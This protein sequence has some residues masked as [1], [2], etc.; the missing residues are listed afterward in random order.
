MKFESQQTL[1]FSEQSQSSF[2]A[3]LEQLKKKLK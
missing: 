1:I 3:V 2:R